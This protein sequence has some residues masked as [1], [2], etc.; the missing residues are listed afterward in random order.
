MKDELSYTLSRKYSIAELRS[1]DNGTKAI[2]INFYGLLL[3][4][5]MKG[6]SY[7]FVYF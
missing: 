7:Y 1:F 2:S 6:R 3:M 4:H 5:R